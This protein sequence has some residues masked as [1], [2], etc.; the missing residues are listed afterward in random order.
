MWN[1]R[2]C[3]IAT[4]ALARIAAIAACLLIT[5]RIAISAEST[6]VL[7]CSYT[8]WA[9]AQTDPSGQSG[10][11]SKTFT[12]DLTNNT[13]TDESGSSYSANI[14]ASRIDLHGHSTGPQ[15]GWIDEKYS[16]DRFGKSI[17]GI[18]MSHAPNPSFN[19]LITLD[20]SCQQIT[21]P[22]F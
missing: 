10:T 21:K 4:A 16:I 11:G 8:T 6:L 18:K 22:A 9:K 12:V 2:P 7:R 15:G 14:A 13:A 1:Y 20:G 19:I 5:S 17:T 3:A